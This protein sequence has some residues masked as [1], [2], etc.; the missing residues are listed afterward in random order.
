MRFTYGVTLQQA[1]EVLEGA[2]GAVTQHL[3]ELLRNG[4]PLPDRRRGEQPGRV[5]PG[6]PLQHSLPLGRF[7]QAPHHEQV[8]GEAGPA[9]QGDTQEHQGLRT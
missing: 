9:G 1:L 4:V 3:I 8:E 5:V 2:D 7:L 6:L